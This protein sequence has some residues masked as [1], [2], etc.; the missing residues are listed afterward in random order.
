[1]INIIISTIVALAVSIG[2]FF[3]VQHTNQKE[4]LNFAGFSDPFLSVQ[5]ATGPDSGECLETDGTNNVWD[6]CATGG[7]GSGGGGNSKWATST[8]TTIIPNGSGGIIVSASSTISAL[9]VTYATSTFATSTNTFATTASST[10]LFSTN[11]SF[12]SLTLTSA[13]PVSSGGTGQTSFGQGWLHSDGSTFTSSTSPTVN[14][15]TATS[16]SATST[17]STGGFTVGASQ[18]VVQQNS[19]N[20]GIGTS[21][22]SGSNS[23]A[24]QGQ[25]YFTGSLGIGIAAPTHPLHVVGNIKLTGALIGTESTGQAQ[26]RMSDAG[27]D[28]APTY[29]FYGDTDTG[30]RRPAANSISLVTGGVERTRLDST[31]NLGIGTT[32]PYAKLSVVGEVVARNFTATSTTAA[33][34]FPY[35]STTAVTVSGS[36]YNTSL[37]DGC[38]NVT[39][40]LIGST[41]S[42]CASG[43]GGANSKW[44]TSTVD[45]ASI[46][47]VGAGAV[48]IGTST[49]R[50]NLQIASSTRPQ[51]VLSD[52]SLTSD[53][54]SFR[55]AG[56][57]LYIG[58]SSP[59]TF[60]T[61]SLSA[62]QLN[63]TGNA[64]LSIASSTPFAT[65]AVHTVSGQYS[66]QFV[67]ASSTATSLRLNNSGHLFLP[68]LSI[69]A[70]A[71]TYTMCGEATTFEAIWDTTTCVLS[72]A[73]YKTNVA[74]LD[75]GLEELMKVRPVVFNYKPTGDKV[76]DE[77]LN[78]NHQQIGVI[79]DEI[80][81]ID[82]RLVVYDNKGEIRG[83]NYEQFTSWI[84]KS[85]QELYQK[86]LGI[87]SR[88]EKL[89][90]ENAELKS[91]L[92]AIEAKLK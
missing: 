26:L 53:H 29:T 81:K 86:V 92:D 7:G 49:P 91:R 1:M 48:G 9:T 65:L 67:V 35:A 34:T 72:A 90:K 44:A 69:D 82:S 16:T 70:A 3:T 2:G 89:E 41:G 42:A 30:F 39:S 83:F 22:P 31:G 87:D 61:S 52:A 13:L 21:T 47:N 14:Y 51:L 55:N 79:A 46:F 33:S 64:G 5:L 43:S 36:L 73:K 77:N 23:L 57:N 58:T 50:W 4:N 62:L 54:W 84:A 25:S 85:V 6:T 59:S 11:A 74:D 45:T 78:I 38:V 56:G 12:G 17:I 18:F 19:G 66:N 32:S 63:D 20:V 68:A 60:A 27:T 71:H 75:L 76:Y 8:G 40:G 88:I 80:E 10:N 37:S 24:V 15:F 28:G